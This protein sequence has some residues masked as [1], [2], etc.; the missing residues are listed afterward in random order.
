MGKDIFLL[1]IFGYPVDSEN[2][3]YYGKNTIC[4]KPSWTNVKSFSDFDE[5]ELLLNIVNFYSGLKILSRVLSRH[6]CAL[7]Y[8]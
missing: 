1:R 8:H 7:N 3:E 4:V 5:H 2:T 6:I